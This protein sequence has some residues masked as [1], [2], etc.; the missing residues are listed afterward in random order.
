[1][2]SPLKALFVIK[3]S[4][5]TRLYTMNFK[6]Y[7]GVESFSCKS[8]DEAIDFLKKND[9]INI[10]VCEDIID[11]E[12]C[13]IKL[14]YYIKSISADVAMI[15]LGDDDKLK[16]YIT[17]IPKNMW[18]MVIRTAANE[19]MISSK[20]MAEK[21]HS[22]FFKIDWK[23]LTTIKMTNIIVYKKNVDDEQYEPFLQA[24]DALDTNLIC[25]MHYHGKFEFFVLAF[26]RVKLMQQFN[27]DMRKILSSEGITLDDR[28]E[29][30]KDSFVIAHHSLRSFG[31]TP[32][33]VRTSLETIKSI[34]TMVE[35][36][37][38]LHDFIQKLK[39]CQDSYLY[40]HSVLSAV[41]CS[42]VINGL[43]WG[44][45]DQHGQIC[46]LCFFHDLTLVDDR[47]AKI[48]S[49]I[50]L[51]TSRLREGIERQVLHHA[52]DAC[53]IVKRF[54][55]KPFGAEI[56][57]LQHH[58][59]LTGI[60]FND[61]PPENL[62]PFSKVFMVCEEIVEY[63]LDDIHKFS[64]DDI[65]T[66]IDNKYQKRSYKKIIDVLKRETQ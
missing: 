57:I 10:I 66:E 41:L 29:S 19:L 34:E 32:D 36:S 24:G 1:M 48:N 2:N 12:S 38:V 43:G 28:I 23:I 40:Q 9:D 4:S 63:M 46:F 59:S 35:T 55:N 61:S 47:M 50:S 64:H 58:G 44:S 52:L 18:R 15:A 51:K 45:A 31:I 27:E 5:I 37:I 60:G 11:G 6:I 39:K 65:F 54:P 20:Q 25:E 21:Y 62:S 8:V 3:D 30:T 7:M 13:A 17:V 49:N 42:K 16:K 22:T 56:L 26:E 33:I 53:D 14:F